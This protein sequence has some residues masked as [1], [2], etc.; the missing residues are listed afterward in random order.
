MTQ[1]E[2]DGIV[3]KIWNSNYGGTWNAKGNTLIIEP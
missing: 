1:A 3:R 2:Y